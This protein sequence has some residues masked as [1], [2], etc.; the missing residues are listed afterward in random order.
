ML[1]KKI[2]ALL[3]TVALATMLTGCSTVEKIDTP[4]GEAEAAVEETTE[5]A[6][7]EGTRDNPAALGSTVEIGD[8]AGPQF[9]VT[10]SD[11]NLD[12]GDVIAKANQFN[13]PAE[14]GMQF[15]TAAVT[16]TYVGDETGN[17]WLDVQIEFVSAAGTTHTT[18]DAF[19]VGP[20]PE[21]TSIN[22]MYNGATETG[23]IVLMVPSADIEAGTFSISSL[24]G[25]EKYFISVV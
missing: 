3:A 16:Y 11:V 12:A 10:I 4:A 7:E 17:P 22:E 19:V 20:E 21:I 13:D 15:V 18:G 14:D 5:T 8:N 25:S 2:S 9:Q 6:A 1:S 23:N 24:F